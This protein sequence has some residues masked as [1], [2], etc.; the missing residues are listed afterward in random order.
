MIVKIDANSHISA[1][2]LGI[3]ICKTNQGIM[4]V[5]YITSSTAVGTKEQSPNNVLGH[6]AVIDFLPAIQLYYFIKIHKEVKLSIPALAYRLLIG[7]IQ[8]V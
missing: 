5:Y 3:K 8:L 1:T 6:H 7:C 4:I 2:L